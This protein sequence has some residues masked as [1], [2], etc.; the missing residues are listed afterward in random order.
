VF[1]ITSTSAPKAA[2]AD[3]ALSTTEVTAAATDRKFASRS[4]MEQVFLRSPRLPDTVRATEES[5]AD[6]VVPVWQSTVNAAAEPHAVCAHRT[7]RLRGYG[8]LR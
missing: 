4:V 5:S 3:N 1:W 2:P 8:W 6:R 7:P